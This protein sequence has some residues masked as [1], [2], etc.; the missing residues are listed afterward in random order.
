M[1]SKYVQQKSNE[2]KIYTAKKYFTWTKNSKLYNQ[3]Y[4]DWMKIYFDWMKI[5]FYIRKKSDIIKI[6][7]TEYK[8]IF[9][10]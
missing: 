2:L 3:N 10:E 9:I 7:F 5:H 1:K 8:F 4:L 6:Y